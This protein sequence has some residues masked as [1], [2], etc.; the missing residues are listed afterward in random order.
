MDFI[1]CLL[2]IFGLPFG[3]YRLW[4]RQQEKEKEKARLE[5]EIKNNSIK[6]AKSWIEE[7][8]VNKC[9]QPIQTEMLLKNGEIA[10]WQEDAKLIETRAVR[11]YQSGYTGFRVAKGMYVGGS[12]GCSTSSQEWQ[13]LARGKLCITNQ[14][15]IFD[16][17][18]NDRNIP[19]KKIIAVNTNDHASIEVSTETRQKSMIFAVRNGYIITLI[20]RICAQSKDPNDLSGMQFDIRFEE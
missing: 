4:K 11:H 2:I 20:I 12:K 8:K 1:I 13:V 7:L 3:A 17:D 6:D 18:S 10:Y 16:G 5:E 19:L 14:R 15:L 9:L